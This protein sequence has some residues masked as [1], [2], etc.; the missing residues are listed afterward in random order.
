MKIES[1]FVLI[2]FF[3][4]I[5]G[6]LIILFSKIPFLGKIPGNIQVKRDNFVVF[7]PYHFL[8]HNFNNTHVY[9]ESHN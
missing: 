4:I 2:G 5:A 9:L 8:H 3:L 6:I 1:P 7:F